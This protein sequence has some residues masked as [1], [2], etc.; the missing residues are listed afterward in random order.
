MTAHFPG[1]V[2]PKKEQTSMKHISQVKIAMLLLAMTVTVIGSASAAVEPT[3]RNLSTQNFGECCV[4]FN[5]EVSISEPNTLK[6]AVVTWD[7]GYYEYVN[8][9]YTAG[10]SVNGGACQLATFGADVLPN[11]TVNASDSNLHVTFQWTIL[12]ADG[13]LV[14]GVNTFAVCGGGATAGDSINIYNNT[15]N[16][17]LN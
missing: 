9:R 11:L 7:T 3:A 6:P 1:A 2:Q 5:I 15:L 4:P 10:L 12:P 8:D 16:V 17:E 14:K 13:V